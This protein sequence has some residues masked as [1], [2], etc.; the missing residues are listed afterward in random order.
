[1]LQRALGNRETAEVEPRPGR[2][3]GAL[4]REGGLGG[5]GAAVERPGGPRAD[6]T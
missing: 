3:H 1:M 2:R 5:R 4:P 6:V